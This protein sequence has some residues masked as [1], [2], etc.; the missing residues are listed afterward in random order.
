MYPESA[1]EDWEGLIDSWRTPVYISPLHDKDLTEQGDE[2]KPHWHVMI[3][4][5]GP[6]S[7]ENVLSMIQPLKATTPQK[8]ASAKGLLRYFLHLDNKDKHQYSPADIR[9][10]SGAN[11]N[12]YLGAEVE[13]Q[14]VKDML[15]FLHDCEIYEFCD[16]MN[17][18]SNEQQHWLSLLFDKPKYTYI[19]SRYIDSQRNK[20]A[21]ES[22]QT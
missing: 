19:I 17:Y 11:K 3:T 6:K 16:F 14:T 22:R 2:K 8:V 15:Q 10:F 1:P 12:Q 18:A 7:Y 21:Q 5:D 20:Y 4:F 13:E 9:C